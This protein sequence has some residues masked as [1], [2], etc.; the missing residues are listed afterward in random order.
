[1]KEQERDCIPAG[2]LLMDEVYIIGAKA[3]DGDV[4]RELRHAVKDCLGFAPVI[5][6]SPITYNT[7]HI[8][9]RHSAY[10]WLLV[11]DLCWEIHELELLFES[12][13]SVIWY[14]DLVGFDICHR[15]V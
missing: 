12:L 7:F 2:A 6:V 15:A 4:S 13:D 14:A 9:Q 11:L 3:I 5:F 1:M 10:P 8:G